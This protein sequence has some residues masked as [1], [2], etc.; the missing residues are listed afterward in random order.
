MYI[1][2]L[3]KNKAW[4]NLLSI[5]TSI[6]VGSQ[7]LYLPYFPPSCKALMINK[8]E[9]VMKAISLMLRTFGWYHE[10]LK[11]DWYEFFYNLKCDMNFYHSFVDDKGGEIIPKYDKL[12]INV[13]N[14]FHH[15]YLKCL[16]DKF[17]SLW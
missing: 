5:L 10:C 6:K 9:E 17:L 13:C 2:I 15:I 3:V 7:W 4:F 16:L 14:V 1:L 11:Y 8:R 12:M